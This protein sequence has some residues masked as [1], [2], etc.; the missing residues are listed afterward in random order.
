MSSIASASR[1]G[2]AA[3]LTPFLPLAASAALLYARWP[4]LP[5][6]FPIHW[7]AGGQADGWAPRTPATVLAPI[8]L[9]AFLVGLFLLIGSSL[10]MGRR[11]AVAAEAAY[12][13]AVRRLSWRCCLAATWMVSLLLSTVALIPVLSPS[14]GPGGTLCLILAVAFGGGGVLLGVSFAGLAQLRSV[15]P[16]AGGTEASQEHWRWG[17]FYVNPDDPSIWVEKRFGIGYTL[18][19]GRPAGRLLLVAILM[20]PIVLLALTLLLA[21]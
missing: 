14:L 2:A 3:T 7:G 16:A 1:P 4:S 13:Q 8:V 15:R 11:A 12:R 20:L 21:R 6:R 10:P 5:A 18:N 17:S 9:G 19:L